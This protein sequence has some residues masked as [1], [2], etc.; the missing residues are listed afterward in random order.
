MSLHHCLKAGS[1]TFPGN[2]PATSQKL[3]ATQTP[4]TTRALSSIPHAGFQQPCC[5]PAF[6][7]QDLAARRAFKM[8]AASCAP[9]SSFYSW[10]RFRCD[11]F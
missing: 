11:V 5:P 1:F 6:A 4:A 7:P 10:E 8:G 3:A 2:L 9:S